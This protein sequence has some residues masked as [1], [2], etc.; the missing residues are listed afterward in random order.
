M[1]TYTRFVF[2]IGDRPKLVRAGID[3]NTLSFRAEPSQN[4]LIF[5][6]DHEHEKYSLTAQI[7]SKFQAATLSHSEFSESEIEDAPYCEVYARHRFG[8]PQPEQE[9]RWRESTYDLSEYCN[10][11]GSGATQRDSFAILKEPRW[12]GKRN[13]G[14]LEWASDTLFGLSGAIEEIAKQFEL[15]KVAV[16]HTNRVDSFKSVL[17]LIPSTSALL[18]ESH[19]E[20]ESE[21]RLCRTPRFSYSYVGNAP[22]PV[23][24]KS[25]FFTSQQWFGSGASSFKVLYVSKELRSAM[26]LLFRGIC[27][28]PCLLAGEPLAWAG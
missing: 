22:S 20:L 4:F 26:A 14:T 6:V 10:R 15:D 21:C 1:K 25:H 17:Q 5:Q 23:F 2:D 3:E 8:F 28:R 19:L 24:A 13:T 16:L 11:C 27:F 7:A 9:N 18:T 12:T